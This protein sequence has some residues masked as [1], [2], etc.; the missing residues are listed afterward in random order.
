MRGIWF[1]GMI[2]CQCLEN[3]NAMGLC[4]GIVLV[5]GPCHC[6]FHEPGFCLG[7]CRCFFC[8]DPC[9]CFFFLDPCSF[10]LDFYLDSCQI[11]CPCRGFCLDFCFGS[12]QIGC[13]CRGFLLPPHPATWQDCA[14]NVC[15]PLLKKIQF[16]ECAKYFGLMLRGLSLAEFCTC[17]RLNN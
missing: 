16:I 4:P 1:L 11:P 6:L 9:R 2:K 14:P 10:C 13:P 17:I 12:C 3:L 8:L 15:K 5:L 7:P